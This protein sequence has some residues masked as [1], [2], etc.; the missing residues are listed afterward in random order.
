MKSIK[1]RWLIAEYCSHPIYLGWHLYLRDDPRYQKRNQ[2]G[3]WGWIR[4]PAWDR[5][6]KGNKI[7]EFFSSALGIDLQDDWTC[8][9][10]GLAAFVK[11]FPI[12]GRKVGGEKR[13]GIAVLEDY[14]GNLTIVQS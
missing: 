9:Q 4:G 6:R 14:W 7:V 1:P 5:D 10:H 3:G 12:K 8:P 2:D 11:R 13:G